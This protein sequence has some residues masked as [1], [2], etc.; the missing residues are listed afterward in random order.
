MFST[1]GSSSRSRTHAITQP[2]TSP[3]AIPPAAFQTNSQLASSSEKP[4]PAAA[5]SAIR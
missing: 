3:T 1:S 4:A 2:T 5:A